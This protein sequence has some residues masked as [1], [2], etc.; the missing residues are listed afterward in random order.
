VV[1]PQGQPDAENTTNKTSDEVEQTNIPTQSDTLEIS[2]DMKQMAA[3]QS[4]I[5]SG[6]YDSPEVLQSVAE[7]ILRALKING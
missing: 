1:S 2:N 5:E 4:K 3:I 7:K 6:F